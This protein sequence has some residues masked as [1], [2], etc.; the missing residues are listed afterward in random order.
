MVYTKINTFIQITINSVFAHSSAQPFPHA[1]AQGI[2]HQWPAG[3]PPA[4]G[5][6]NQDTAD[7]TPCSCQRV[8]CVAAHGPATGLPSVESGGPGVK[9]QPPTEAGIGVLQGRSRG[10]V[11]QQCRVAASFGATGGW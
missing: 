6:S 8:I 10:T 5:N 4:A 1:Q 7:T 9:S 3:L 2:G 11:P